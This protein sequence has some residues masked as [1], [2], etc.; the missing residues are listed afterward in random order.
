MAK[1]FKYSL[2]FLLKIKMQLIFRTKRVF[3]VTM[4][5]KNPKHCQIRVAFQHARY[6][7]KIY[8]NE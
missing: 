1:R 2:Q 4:L 3:P 7:N 6:A 8:S 5:D